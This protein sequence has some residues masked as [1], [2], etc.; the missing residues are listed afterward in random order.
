MEVSP[1]LYEC[2]Q[3]KGQNSRG[4]VRH[5]PDVWL[6]GPQAGGHGSQEGGDRS[7]KTHT[8]LV[9]GT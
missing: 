8:Q 1:S 4:V 3:W 5:R 2:G 7:L 9:L 6:Q